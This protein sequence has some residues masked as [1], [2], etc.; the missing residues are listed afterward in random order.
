MEIEEARSELVSHFFIVAAERLQRKC[1]IGKIYTVHTFYSIYV[2]V[3][4]TNAL[5]AFAAFAVAIC[6]YC[7][8]LV[9]HLT[10]FQVNMKQWH[11]QK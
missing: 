11:L 5:S 3:Y 7:C 10:A 2:T 9:S 4:I 8:L 1:E 6:F